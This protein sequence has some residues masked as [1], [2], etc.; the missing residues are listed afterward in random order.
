MQTSVLEAGTLVRKSGGFPLSW[1]ENSAHPGRYS[2]RRLVASKTEIYRKPPCQNSL[3]SGPS[4]GFSGVPAEDSKILLPR[5]VLESSCRAR[6][7]C[8]PI[9]RPLLP[10]DL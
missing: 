5:G 8:E 4:C 7:S 3:T 2:L 10:E 9:F 1:A 6:A